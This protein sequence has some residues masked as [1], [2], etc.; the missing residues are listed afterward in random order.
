MKFLVCKSKNII[1]L[2][3][4]DP[5]KVH[6]KTLSDNLEETEGNLLRFQMEQNLCDHILFPYNFR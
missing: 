6:I 1:N 2:G 4:I 5:D 3:F